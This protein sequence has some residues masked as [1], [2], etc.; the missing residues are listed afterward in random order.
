MCVYVYVYLYM[1]VYV[2]HLLYVYSWRQIVMSARLSGSLSNMTWQLM[3]IER[4]TPVAT[5]GPR[6]CLECSWSEILDVL[7]HVDIV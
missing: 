6:V 2:W 4:G 1:Y 3:N 5:S 7:R